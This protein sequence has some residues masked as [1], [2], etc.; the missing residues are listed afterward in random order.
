MLYEVI[1]IAPPVEYQENC[2][3]RDMFAR[4]MRLLLLLG[5]KKWKDSKQLA[6]AMPPDE[7]LNRTAFCRS[8]LTGSLTGL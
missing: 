3:A 6:A 7:R 1:T 4:G 5:H 8:V 2:R